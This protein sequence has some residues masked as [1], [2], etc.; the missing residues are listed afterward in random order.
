MEK[1]REFQKNIYFCLMDYAKAFDCVDHNK[2]WKTLREMGIPG[3]LTFLLRN[4]YAGQEATVR[5]GHGTTDW[6]Q[7]G[8]GVCQ[9]SILP[10]CLFNLYTEFSSAQFTSFQL[11]SSFWFFVIPWIAAHQASLFITNSRIHSDLCPSNHWCHPAIS[12]SVVPF[13]SCPQFPPASES[14]PMSQLFAWGGQSTGVAAL[15]SFLPKNT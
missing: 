6:F 9:G 3:H 1:A 13:S 4:L 10:P 15:A 14:F 2:L 7:I 5:T 11:L 12:S 8:K